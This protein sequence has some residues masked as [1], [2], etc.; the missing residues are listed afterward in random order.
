M[1]NHI[2]LEALIESYIPN[3]MTDHFDEGPQV[4]FD[5]TVIKVIS[6]PAMR[7]RSITI[8]HDLAP[9]ES[10]VWR[11]QGLRVMLQIDSDTIAGSQQVFSGA[12]LNI[13][14]AE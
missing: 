14:Q 6:P 13:R 8:F 10:S 7:D 12:V 9:Q 2:E 3:A 1:E 5:A 4:S 11:K